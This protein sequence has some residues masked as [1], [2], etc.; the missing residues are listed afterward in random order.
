MISTFNKDYLT[1]ILETTKRIEINTIINDIKCTKEYPFKMVKTHTCVNN[2]T[3]VERQ[4]GLCIINYELKDNED[5]KEIEEK[6]IQDVKEEMKNLNISEVDKGDIIIK[7][8]S[9]TITISTSDNQKNG[10][11][12]NTTNIDLGQCEDKIKEAYNIP[13]N[14]SL[15]ILKLE[16]KQEG[17]Q[18]PKIDYEVY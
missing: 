16:V 3:I 17:L 12:P 15:F 14:K 7:Q 8:K 13:K 1:S 5:N 18:I 6:A 2:C 9:S 11:S 4:K 10:K